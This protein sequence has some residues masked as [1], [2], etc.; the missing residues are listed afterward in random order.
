MPHSPV[1]LGHR[2]SRFASS[3]AENTVA[4]FDLA[5]KHGCDGFEFDVRLTASGRAV[6]CHDPTV[7]GVTVAKAQSRQLRQ[8]PVLRDVLK[9]Y[10]KRAFLDIELKVLGL[11]SELL[12]ALQEHPPAR[13][14][15]VSSF[16]PE[17]LNDLRLRSGET[18]LGLICERRKQLDRWQ[19]LPVECVIAHSSLITQ[20]LVKEL[21]DAGKRLIAWTV[22]DAPSM[23]R[24]AEWDIDGI[25]SDDTALLAKTFS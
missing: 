6:I 8:L 9:R 1:L 13:G 3:V 15:V 16:L 20:D 7:R 17:V 19:K 12:I 2:G 22:N 4:A 23:L 18:P 25:I 14:Y 10:A 24:L 21:H 11:D 5:L